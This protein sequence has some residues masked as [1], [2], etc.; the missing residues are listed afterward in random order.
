MVNTI[1]INKIENFD[2]D[3]LEEEKNK[4]RQTSPFV[5]IDYIKSSIEI[6]IDLKIQEKLESLKNPSQSQDHTIN[7]EDEIND[8]EKLLRKAEGENRTH[9]KVNINVNRFYRSNIK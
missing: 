1:I 7:D 4:L 3:S 9:I 2:S 6:L 8:Y 5:I